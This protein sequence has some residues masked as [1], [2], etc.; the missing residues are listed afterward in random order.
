MIKELFGKNKTTH[1]LVLN[2]MYYLH[3][4]RKKGNTTMFK[5]YMIESHSSIAMWEADRRFTCML[6]CLCDY[7]RQ[8]K[9]DTLILG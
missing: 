4:Q 6:Y 8:W 9:T 7:Q 1:I 2:K 5:T 3:S